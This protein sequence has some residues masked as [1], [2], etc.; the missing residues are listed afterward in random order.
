[1]AVQDV[2]MLVDNRQAV[3]VKLHQVVLKRIHRGHPGQEAMLVVSKNLWWSH[4]HKG[5][6]N[7]EEDYLSCTRYGKNAKYLIPKNA[8]KPLALLTQPAQELQ[9]DYACPI[10]YHK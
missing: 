5:M 2:C 3:P 9:L 10:E 6:V 8:S 4:M 7:L 1:M